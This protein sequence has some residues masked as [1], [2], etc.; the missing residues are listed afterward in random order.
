MKI[1]IHYIDNQFGRLAAAAIKL[2]V[3]N[4]VTYTFTIPANTSIVS[5][6]VHTLQ[7]NTSLTTIINLELIPH[8]EEVVNFEPLED[9]VLMYLLGVHPPLDSFL[10]FFDRAECKIKWFTNNPEA[11]TTFNALSIGTAGNRSTIP[12]LTEL[13][14]SDFEDAPSFQDI[15]ETS[16]ALS[17]LLR[18]TGAGVTEDIDTAQGINVMRKSIDSLVE[19]LLLESTPKAE[20]LETY[21]ILGVKVNSLIGLIIPK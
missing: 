9:T 4:L 13:I 2:K 8:V 7:G 17:R 21:R 19:L 3:Q 12:G 15:L 11:I 16:G 14:L 10:E 5:N 6:W 20:L 1:Q 18:L